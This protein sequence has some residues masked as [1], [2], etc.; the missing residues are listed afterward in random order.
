MYYVYIIVITNVLMNN[1]YSCYDLYTSTYT[2]TCTYTGISTSYYK[3]TNN[4]YIC[5]D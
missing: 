4:S 2:Y 3:C 1:S 5:Y